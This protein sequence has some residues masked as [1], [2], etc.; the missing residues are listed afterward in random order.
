MATD[1]HRRHDDEQRS[2]LRRALIFPP[3]ARNPFVHVLAL[4]ALGQ[5]VG[6][7]LGNPTPGSIEQVLSP[8]L[9]D[10][11]GLGLIGFWCGMIAAALSRAL[12]AAARAD[13]DDA[14]QEAREAWAEATKFRRINVQLWTALDAWDRHGRRLDAQVVDHGGVPLPRPA[15][16]TPRVLD[17]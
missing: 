11:W 5:G 14:R 15:D 8:V 16:L 17:D 4:G 9:L 6:I 13:A 7:V 2:A 1:H 12:Y 3:P 10:V